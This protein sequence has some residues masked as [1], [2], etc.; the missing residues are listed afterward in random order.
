MS[1][2]FEREDLTIYTFFKRTWKQIELATKNHFPNRTVLLCP[3]ILPS[4]ESKRLR[5]CRVYHE[6]YHQEDTAK[7][8]ENEATTVYSH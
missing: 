3:V 1:A 4:V 7:K 2:D 5:N 8:S 6:V